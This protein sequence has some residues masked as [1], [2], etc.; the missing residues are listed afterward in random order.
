MLETPGLHCFLPGGTLADGSTW[1]PGVFHESESFNWVRWAWGILLLFLVLYSH[2]STGFCLKDVS[3]ISRLRR[4]PQITTRA[5]VG[6]L[7]STQQLSTKDRLT[8]EDRKQSIYLA[9]F[10]AEHRIINPKQRDSFG[11]H[12]EFSLLWNSVVLALL[13]LSWLKNSQQLVS[14]NTRC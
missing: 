9:I 5:G 11:Y 8:Q 12:S 2:L 1:V 14:W 3:L 6:W 10:E 13:Q 4:A 7:N